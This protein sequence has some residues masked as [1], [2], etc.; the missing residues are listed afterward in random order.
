[1]ASYTLEQ[2]A[3]AL[4]P[5]PQNTAFGW[6]SGL[7]FQYNRQTGETV[8]SWSTTGSGVGAY[9]PINDTFVFTLNSKLY[10]LAHDQPVT[11]IAS[12]TGSP[13]WQEVCIAGDLVVLYSEASNKIAVVNLYNEILLFHTTTVGGGGSGVITV[14]TY[15]Q[16]RNTVYIC[17]SD[18]ETI[19]AVDLDSMTVT[20]ND[21]PGANFA[22]PTYFPVMDVIAISSGGLKPTLWRVDP[23]SM[24]ILDSWGADPYWPENYLGAK[25][26]IDTY[27]P[28]Q[29][30]LIGITASS[31]MAATLVQFNERLSAGQVTLHS[32]VGDLCERAGL[33]PADYDV[34]EL[35][36]MVDGY[37]T[38]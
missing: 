3:Y 30:V 28:E 19:H 36:E 8:E 4:W 16:A 24:T 12:F 31:M 29:G 21:F 38:T 11:L 32:I 33:D 22:W 10:E 1:V 18:G 34:S 2:D 7:I 20:A 23:D 25:I 37:K 26:Y 27:N 9:R 15:D 35:T 5:G 17:S 14:T 6:D 13:L